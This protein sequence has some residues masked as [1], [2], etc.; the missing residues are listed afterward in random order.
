MEGAGELPQDVPSCSM[1]PGPGFPHSV[2]PVCVSSP[3]LSLSLG[4]STTSTQGDMQPSQASPK[5]WHALVC[6][7]PGCLQSKFHA[8]P[9]CSSFAA[10]D[11][12]LQQSLFSPQSLQTPGAR[13]TLVLSSLQPVLCHNNQNDQGC[14]MCFSRWLQNVRMSEQ[15]HLAAI[16]LQDISCVVTWPPAFHPLQPSSPQLTETPQ[17]F[18]CIKPLHTFLGQGFSRTQISR[19]SIPSTQ[20]SS[21]D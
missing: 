5:G 15:S 21:S 3:G 4:W 8:V 7:C 6:G 18:G 17:R 11:T 16:S 13:R 2:Q 12:S 10:Q 9:L 19:A 1:P 14:M 20:Q